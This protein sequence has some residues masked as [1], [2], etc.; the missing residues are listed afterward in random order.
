MSSH[1]L[2]NWVWFWRSDP[3]VSTFWVVGSKACSTLP[4]F[5]CCWWLNSSRDMHSTNWATTPGPAML[6]VRSCKSQSWLLKSFVA[7]VNTIQIFPSICNLFCCALVVKVHCSCLHAVHTVAAPDS[8]WHMLSKLSSRTKSFAFF[9]QSLCFQFYFF[10]N[11]F[12]QPTVVVY[13]CNPGLGKWKQEEFKV[14]LGEGHHSWWVWGQPGLNEIVSR[15]ENFFN[16]F[17]WH[18]LMRH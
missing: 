10:S 18:M 1:M 9:L 5:M 15:L 12:P 14:I 17:Q 2:Y 3:L 6:K 16:Y 7:K 8:T 13:N 11:F 4:S